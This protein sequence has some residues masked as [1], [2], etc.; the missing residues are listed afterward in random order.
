MVSESSDKPSGFLPVETTVN[1]LNAGFTKPPGKRSG[2]LRRQLLYT[3]LYAWFIFVSA[4]DIL[5]TWVILVRGGREVN[6]IAGKVIERFGRGGVVAFKF[7]IVVFVVIVCELVGR[8][9]HDLG[10]RLATWAIILPGAAVAM[11]FFQLLLAH[12]E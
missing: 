4:L 12:G 6:W 11:A 5:F 1:V 3:N 2:L 9:R 10:R 7:G 8:R